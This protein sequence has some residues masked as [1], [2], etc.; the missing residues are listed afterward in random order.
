MKKK[1]TESSAS[2]NTYLKQKDTIAILEQSPRFKQL[3]ESFKQ[4]WGTK[5]WW[6]AEIEGEDRYQVKNMYEDDL[7]VIR[8]EFRLG[9]E[10]EF[11]ILEYIFSGEKIFPPPSRINIQYD[12]LKQ[13][14]IIELGVNSTINDIR[15]NWSVIEKFKKMVFGKDRASLKP[16]ENLSR[17]REIYS[18]HNEGKSYKEISEIMGLHLSHDE[19]G[20][21][22]RRY[23]NRLQINKKQP[24]T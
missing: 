19:V 23:I 16:I 12:P 21:A 17:D 5:N 10:W 3:C 14:I 15:D 9:P 8:K 20:K 6:E 18:L 1:R 2:R 22:C 24:D 11:G 4:K 7:A 13:K